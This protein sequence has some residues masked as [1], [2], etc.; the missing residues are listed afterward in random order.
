M[1][2]EMLLRSY[3]IALTIIQFWVEL[4]LVLCDF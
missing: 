4:C 3:D 1:S 2:F